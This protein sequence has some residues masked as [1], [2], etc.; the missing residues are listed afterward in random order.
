MFLFVCPLID[1]G[2]EIGLGLVERN[3][4]EGSH[5][6]TRSLYGLKQASKQWFI[7]LKLLVFTN[8]KQITHCLSNP[9]LV[10]SR[11]FLYISMV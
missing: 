7:K 5:F 2:L 4:I 1:L 10:V 8:R 11:Q 6:S 3:L 9:I